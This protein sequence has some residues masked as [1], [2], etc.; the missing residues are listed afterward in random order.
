MEGP[1]AARTGVPA[2]E[3]GRLA[4]RVHG[5][6]GGAVGAVLGMR[7]GSS[8][9][10]SVRVTLRWGRGR[11][12]GGPGSD[13]APRGRRTGRGGRAAV[14]A[15]PV[16]RDG[17]RASREGTGP[18]AANSAGAVRF[19]RAREASTT[20]PAR[21]SGRHRR[22]PTKFHADSWWDGTGAPARPG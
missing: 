15:V 3:G 6:R 8:A 16:G 14:T 5:R 1:G 7:A 2:G 20:L 17:G 13:H 21:G 12:T 4:R 18:A 19:L 11:R 10:W 22:K 9:G